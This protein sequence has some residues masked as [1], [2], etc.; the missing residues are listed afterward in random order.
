MV[1]SHAARPHPSLHAEPAARRDR[2]GQPGGLHALP[3]PL[4]ARR[5]VVPADRTR[6]PARG[7]RR[8]RRLR[9]G[10]RG[11]GACGAAGAARSL[12]AVDA[13]HDLP[14]GRGWVGASLA[15]PASGEPR[16]CAGAGDADRAL[17]ARARGCVA[18]A[19]ASRGGAA[20]R[21]RR[22]PRPVDAARARRVV[23]RR[24]RAGLRARRRPAAAGDRRA[25][26]LRARDVGRIRGTAGARL[27]G[28]RTPGAA[29]SPQQLRRPV[30]GDRGRLARPSRATR[31][32][33]CRRGRCSAA[34][35]SCSGGC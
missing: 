3:V 9:A 27:G 10:G 17:P 22:A 7:R 8:A 20:A 5:D 31:R 34:T 4:A 1:R 25:G 19:A 32:S 23:L 18:S 21:R 24:S 14:G 26:R 2:A 15:G 28:A 33:S 35:A 30:D 16:A 29:R 11:V 6:R 13:R 12:R